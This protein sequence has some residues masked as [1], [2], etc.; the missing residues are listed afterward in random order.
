MES[1]NTLSVNTFLEA[2]FSKYVYLLI[3]SVEEHETPQLQLPTRLRQFKSPNLDEA[4]RC[5]RRLQS[6]PQPRQEHTNE[7]RG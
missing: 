4:L 2:R 7:R 3:V 5:T 6:Q 1:L